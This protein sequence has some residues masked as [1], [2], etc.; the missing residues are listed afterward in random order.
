MAH[1]SSTPLTVGSLVEWGKGNSLLSESA[2]K[3]KVKTVWNDSRKVATGDAFVALRSENDDGHKYVQSAFE[4][5]AVTAIVDRKGL[6]LI[7]EKFHKKCIVVSDTLKAVQKMA[8]RY[9]KEMGLLVVGITGSNGKTT[10]R[11]FIS[12]VLKQVIKVGETYTNW[13]N[14]IGVPLSL[15]KFDGDEWAGVIEMGANHV[16]EI[17]PLSLIAAPDIAVITNIGYAHVGLFG[18]LE[19]TTEAKFEIADGLSKDGFMLLNGDDSRLVKGAK[20]R[21]LKTV[22]FGTGSKCDIRARDILVSEKSVTFSV[23]GVPFELR[24]PG[25]HFLYGVLPAIY[26]ARRCRVPLDLI[27]EAISALK[28]VSLRGMLEQKKGVN[29]IVDCYNANP[30][31]MSHAVRYLADITPDK[32]SRVAIVGDMFELEQYSAKLHIKLGEELVKSDVQ[33]IMAVGKYASFIAQGAMKSG[34]PSR[35]IMQ[36]DDAD[37]ALDV[38]R[39]WL[40]AGETVLLK[41]SRGVRLERVFEGF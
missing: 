34:L 15:L 11:S 7:P 8:A 29:F 19:K 14:H 37:R 27:Q 16:G 9:R 23:D 12:S 31:S 1:K 36:V 30:S 17:H 22:L 40:K 35:K 2:K 21:N 18:S 20:D 33:K 5:G 6:K 32:K 10:T 3:K 13:N 41:G 38:S 4:K 39:S 25:R 24:M 26:I 28:P